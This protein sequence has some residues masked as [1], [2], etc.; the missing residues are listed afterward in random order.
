[1]SKLRLPAND[2]PMALL[3]IKAGKFVEPS[4]ENVSAAAMGAVSSMPDDLR[5]K[6]TNSEG[7]NSYPVASYT[8][9]LIHAEQK[10]SVRGKAL[11]EFLWWAVHD[12]E[13]FAHNLH[14][15]PL[16]EEVVR[17]VETKINSVVSNGK[18]LRN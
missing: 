9:I 4:I 10:D 17:K 15:A 5:T 16:P 7:E 8:Y 3:K 14:Y 13:S 1:M 11:I 6:I 18:P 12:G 2:L